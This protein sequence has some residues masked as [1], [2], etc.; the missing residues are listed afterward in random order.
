[1]S[2]E[3][4]YFLKD[5][6][7][8]FD[9]FFEHDK[10]AQKN[11]HDF[12]HR[13]RGQSRTCT[14]PLIKKKPEFYKLPEDSV[15]LFATVTRKELLAHFKELCIMRNMEINCDILYKSKKIRG[16]CHLYDGQVLSVFIKGSHP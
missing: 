7:Q 10:F 6:D 11:C 5:S 3:D 12:R 2:G 9:N 13:N 1:M 16:F 15:P 14:S 8:L 4:I